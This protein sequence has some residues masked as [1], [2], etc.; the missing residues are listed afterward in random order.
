[1]TNAETVTR[2]A[3]AIPA[4]AGPE[5]RIKLLADILV[6]ASWAVTDAI[7]EIPLARR[8]WDRIARLAGI[9]DV[10]AA[11]AMYDPDR[12]VWDT[13]DWPAPDDQ[14][15]PPTEPGDGPDPWLQHA[16]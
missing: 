12:W 6:K 5:D 15:P 13:S 7:A 11:K 9:P 2:L 8:D 14:D 1:M 10:G 3:A 4:A 16:G